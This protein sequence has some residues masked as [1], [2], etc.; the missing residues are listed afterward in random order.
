MH[1]DYVTSIPTRFGQRPFIFVIP[2][3]AGDPAR[4]RFMGWHVLTILQQR[5]KI[6]EGSQGSMIVHIRLIIAMNA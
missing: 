3:Q 2:I 4:S 1:A 5:H 6:V